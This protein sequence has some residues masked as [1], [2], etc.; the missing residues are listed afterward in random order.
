MKTLSITFLLVVYLCLSQSL[1]AQS[2]TI[3]SK[4]CFDTVDV[5]G[6]YVFVYTKNEINQ[7]I[8]SKSKKKK[9][10][11][12]SVSIGDEYK[13]FFIPLD[14]VT[15]RRTLSSILN[16][17][18]LKNK[19][20]NYIKY[21][22]MD[23]YSFDDYNVGY[24]KYFKAVSE[25]P[26]FVSSDFYITTGSK[27]K[28]CFKIFSLS[29]KWVKLQMSKEAANEILARKAKYLNPLVPQYNIFIFKELLNSD[30]TPLLAGQPVKLWKTLEEFW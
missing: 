13:E 18:L 29:A 6:Y 14:S 8:K 3:I 12:F 26:T 10:K 17:L 16:N 9:G 7:L 25:W 24:L 11:P 23:N 4:S 22:S 2:D 30:L 1:F 21:S 5:S 27:T 19:V 20:E 15:A 28:Y